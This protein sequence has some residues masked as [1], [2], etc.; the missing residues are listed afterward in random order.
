MAHMEVVV[1]GLYRPVPIGDDTAM[2]PAFTIH[3][4]GDGPSVEIDTEVI[5]GHP[6]SVAVRVTSPGK[7]PVTASVLRALAGKLDGWTTE[8]SALVAMRV[9]TG[10]GGTWHAT[11]GGPGQVRSVLDARNRRRRVTPALLRAVGDVWAANPNV[12]TVARHFHVSPRTAYRYVN[13]AREAGHI[14]KEN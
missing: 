13:M 1:H 9:D 12:D 7:E 4:T 2:P 5:D 6:E 10:P 11:Q 8:G 14:D 3:I